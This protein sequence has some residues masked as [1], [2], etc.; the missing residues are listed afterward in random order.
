[1]MFQMMYIKQ[2]IPK[3][4]KEMFEN[5]IDIKPPKSLSLEFVQYSQPSTTTTSD[6]LNL[7]GTYRV[8]NPIYTVPSVTQQIP[9]PSSFDVVLESYNQPSTTKT[10]TE[11]E[12][13]NLGAD[14]QK[15]VKELTGAYIS[16]I[17]NY[18]D[19]HK[20]TIDLKYVNDLVAQDILESSWG[21]SKL[22]YNLGGIKARKGEPYIEANTF[23]YINGKKVKIKDKFR[24]FNSLREFVKFKINMLTN[25]RY[26]KAGVF[27]GNY[28]HSLK[29]AGYYTASESS[30]K[31][32][33]DSI[34]KQIQQLL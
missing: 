9:Q 34:K 30:Y 8:G 27:K 4:I 6:F 24:K 5:Y 29:V 10:E 7:Q 20:D 18:N 25:G 28:A 14:K 23:E 17:Q 32:G 16:E 26:K 31:A 21:K 22:G 19:T 3:Y 13:V 12:N 2:L 11:T 33:L 1:M 15:F